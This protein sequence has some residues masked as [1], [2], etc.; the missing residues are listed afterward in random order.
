M[1]IRIGQNKQKER[2]QGKAEETDINAQTHSSTFLSC[3]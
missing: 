2:T 1:N 3:Q